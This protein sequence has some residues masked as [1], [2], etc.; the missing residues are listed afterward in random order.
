MRQNSGPSDR[1]NRLS[2]V[3]LVRSRRLKWGIGSSITPEIQSVIFGD[4][5]R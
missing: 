3:L 5:I 4:L 2:F 1:H